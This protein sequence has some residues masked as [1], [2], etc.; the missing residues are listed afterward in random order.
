MTTIASHEEVLP[1]SWVQHAVSGVEVD[2][3]TQI[4][5]CAEVDDL[6]AALSCDED[7]FRLDV[8]VDDA[9]GMHPFAGLQNL[10]QERLDDQQLLLHV[11]LLAL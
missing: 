2:P 1:V 7:V 11:A 8:T 6:D 10:L 3:C 4:H 9:Q 5:C